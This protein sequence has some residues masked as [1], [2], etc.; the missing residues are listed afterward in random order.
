MDV[1]HKRLKF[2]A[3]QTDVVSEKYTQACKEAKSTLDHY[4]S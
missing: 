2:L 1:N 4:M 3:A